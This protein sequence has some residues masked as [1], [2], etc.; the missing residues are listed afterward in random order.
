MRT[1][2]AL[3]LAAGAACAPLTT[4]SHGLAADSP[5]QAKVDDAAG[6][7]GAG[8]ETIGTTFEGRPVHLLT[9]A[10]EGQTPPDERPALLIVAGLSGEHLVGTD[11][12]LG[13][14]RRLAEAHADLLTER[15][16]YVVPLVNA[17]AQRIVR[18]AE[19]VRRLTV[20]NSMPTDDDHDARTN[21]DGPD[22]LNGDGVITTMRVLDPPAWL[23]ATLV[24]DEDDPRILRAPEEGEIARYALLTEGLDDDGD[25]AFNEDGPGGVNLDMHFP[26]RWP[27]HNAGAGAYPLEAPSTRA[28]V[29]WLYTRDNIAAVIVYGP[30]DTVTKVPEAGKFDQTGRFP[31]GVEADDK[32]LYG[33]VSEVFKEITGVAEAPAGDPEG[34]FHHWAYAVYGVPT[35]ATPVWVRP[36]QVKRDGEDED[37]AERSRGGGDGG[38]ENDEDGAMSTADIQAI[39]A[40]FQNADEDQRQELM[41]R[42]RDMPEST[43]Q[44]VMAVFQGQDDPGAPGGGADAPA[45]AP[46]RRGDESAW[47]A[48]SDEEREGEGFVDWAPFDHPQ[49]GEVEIGGFVPGFRATPPEGELDRLV[50]EQTRFAAVVLERLPRVGPER[51]HVE[52]VGRRV[53]RVSVELTNEGAFPTVN[54]S[55]RKA[56]RVTPINLRFEGERERLLAGD[57]LQQTW[58]IPGHGGSTRAEW[59]VAGSEGDRVE[60]SLRSSATGERTI[61]ITLREETR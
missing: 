17:D 48:Y 53:W 5:V 21:E 41:Q 11:V 26:A 46:K 44:R 50:D 47:L 52:R 57:R 42:F 61:R 58:S 31:T 32:S 2:Q 60:V 33:G 12:A 23:P 14:A 6:A 29:D 27:E 30:H 13:A 16:L 45:G 19:G 10:G 49:L 43:R 34:A 4:A 22:D 38:A 40:E 51:T 7:P 36:D 24:A 54:A 3:W 9:I 8:V 1:F 28:L 25:G 56:E 39:V 35:F 59:M 15:T 18:S 37:G 55:G 20:A